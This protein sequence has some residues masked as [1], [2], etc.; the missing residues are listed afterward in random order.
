M[1]TEFARAQMITQQI[2]AWEVLDDRVLDAMRRTPREFFV[3]E[4]YAG[5]AFADAAIPLRA[6][7]HM[8]APKIVGRLLQALEAAPGMRALV[9]G[10]GTGYVPACLSAMGASVR[11]I[12]IVPDL[13]E[14]ARRN[15]KRAGFAQVEVVTGDTFNLDTGSDYAVIAVCG[16]L[17]LYV[18][19]FARALAV[20][21]RLFVVVGSSLPQEALLVTRIETEKWDSVALFETAI[22]PL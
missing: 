5:I 14:A 10:C 6:G 3:P 18:D 19:R 15:L 13:A 12:E 11:A 17:P 21:G 9:V 7:Q 20:G 16:A 22:D 4:R 1:Q 8:L 2:R